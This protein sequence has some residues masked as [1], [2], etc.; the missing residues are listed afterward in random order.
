MSKFPNLNT[1][2][3]V[4]GVLTS[5]AQTG[6]CTVKLGPQTA[7]FNN[8]SYVQN[9]VLPNFFFHDQTAYLI[10]RKEGVQVGKMDFLGP[11]ETLTGL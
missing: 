3:I 7:E 10:L 8:L 2:L 4:R 9:F 5:F 11:K 1:L 6:Q